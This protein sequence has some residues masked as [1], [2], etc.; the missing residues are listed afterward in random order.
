M[1]SSTISKIV[2]E[3]LFA[4]LDAQRT[5]RSKKGEFETSLVSIRGF[6]A[7]RM[8]IALADRRHQAV[9]LTRPS[10]AFGFLRHF[11]LRGKT[12]RTHRCRA[13]QWHNAFGLLGVTAPITVPARAIRRRGRDASGRLAD[14]FSP[15]LVSGG[16]PA[17]CGRRHLLS[18]P[19]RRPRRPPRSRYSTGSRLKLPTLQP[20]GL[21]Q[22]A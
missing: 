6:C 9:R 12:K 3:A 5:V 22:E 16:R 14:R 1:T 11:A 21:R 7:R 2:I 10:W 20:A 15:K 13:V 18:K 19:G 4:Q 8:P 17:T